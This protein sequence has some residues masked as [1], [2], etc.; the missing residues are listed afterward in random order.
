ME[1]NIRLH[2]LQFAAYKE[3]LKNDSFLFLSRSFFFYVLP[4]AI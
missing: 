3:V 1:K 4:F 2:P